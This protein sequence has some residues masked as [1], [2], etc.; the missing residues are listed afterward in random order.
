MPGV[1]VV[2]PATYDGYGNP[3][4]SSYD[5]G[6]GSHRLLVS[7]DYENEPE[8]E[9]RRSV[10][11]VQYSVEYL[12]LSE[13]YGVLID[14]D[15]NAGTF[16]HDGYNANSIS[17]VGA[18]GMLIKRKNSDIWHVVYGT[19]LSIDETGATIGWLQV[20]SLHAADTNQFSDRFGLQTFPVLID[21]EVQGGDY[22]KIAVDE[23]EFIEDINT[24]DP[25]PTIGDVTT[26]PDVGD[27]IVKAERETGNGTA[28]VY[29][30]LWYFVE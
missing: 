16:K 5:Q 23:K 10:V 7:P 1:V 17:L 28:S 27:L 9:Q 15:N 8:E 21:L 30:S 29:Y 4:G 18:S 25:L 13:T 19:V 24:V 22:T 12:I 3:I 14:L 2:N 26:V 11:G 20:G 6:V